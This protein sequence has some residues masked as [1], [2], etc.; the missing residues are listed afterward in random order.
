MRPAGRGRRG[1]AVNPSWCGRCGGALLPEGDHFI[2]QAGH[3][4]FLNSKP[5]AGA[6]VLRDGQLLLV[7][8]AIEPW[9][10]WWDIP[11]G[12]LKDGEHPCAGALREVEEETGYI[13]EA[14]ELLGIY[15]DT[16]EYGGDSVFILNIYYLVRI[17][18]GEPRLDA[19]SDALR[20]F[21]LNALPEVAFIHARQVLRDFVE[22]QAPG[23]RPRKDLQ[24][25]QR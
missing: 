21:P 19:E 3:R 7:R 11:G 1:A 9:K 22:Q 15:M 24:G 12:F 25:Q 17:I 20:W 23:A 13:C 2:C 6:L 8:R 10:G 4:T 14:V 5:A 18:G 16:Y